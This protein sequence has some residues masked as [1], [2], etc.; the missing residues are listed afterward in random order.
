MSRSVHTHVEDANVVM[1]TMRARLN[2]VLALE[3]KRKPQESL[4][5]VKDAIAAGNHLL[6]IL[7]DLR[8]RYVG[9]SL[10]QI[11]ATKRRKQIGVV[12]R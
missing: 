11:E 4:R 2:D 10:A 9:A 1:N 7:D 3:G 12:A 8:G 5:E 6:A